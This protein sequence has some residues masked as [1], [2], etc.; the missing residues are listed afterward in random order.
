VVLEYHY[1][2]RQGG[3]KYCAT[4][5]LFPWPIVQTMLEHFFQHLNNGLFPTEGEEDSEIV[6]QKYST[7]K[8]VFS[9]IFTDYPFF[10]DDKSTK[11]W[12]STSQR[13]TFR[14]DLR[15]EVLRW[16]TERYT[17]VERKV[18]GGTIYLRTAYHLWKEILPYTHGEGGKCPAMGYDP[19]P[20]VRLVMCASHYS[21]ED[22]N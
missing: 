2:A 17:I 7:A 6:D 15:D 4:I 21:I 8:E 19:W 13:P 5:C 3:Y 18:A 12:L 22:V 9:A 10:Q 14:E 16:A 11:N 1:F 20:F